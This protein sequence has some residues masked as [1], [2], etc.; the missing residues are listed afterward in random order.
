MLVAT[1]ALLGLLLAPRVQAAI[2]PEAGRYPEW[3]ALP[4]SV[5]LWIA[6]V[7]AAAFLG[8]GIALALASPLL[9]QLSR[10]VEARARG[11][12]AGR[13]ARTRVRARPVAARDG[14]LPG[15]APVL[16]LLGFVPIVGPLSR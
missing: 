7:G 16:L 13:V 12:A 9:E 4:T 3:I 1:F 8:L 15:A 11:L 5:L 10:R 2:L 14:L 6:T